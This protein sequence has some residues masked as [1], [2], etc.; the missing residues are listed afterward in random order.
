MSPMSVLRNVVTKSIILENILLKKGH[1]CR[2]L[3]HLMRQQN[4]ILTHHQ[5]ELSVTSKIPSMCSIFLGRS[6]NCTN[7]N[8]IIKKETIHLKTVKR[9]EILQ[10]VFE[11]KRD[12]FI[13]KKNICC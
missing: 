4:G 13:E 10:D 2:G 8:Y 1:Q 11:K 9:R 3:H 7:S 5:Q 6:F 12:K